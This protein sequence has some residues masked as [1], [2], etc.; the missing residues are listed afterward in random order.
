MPDLS[1]EIGLYS[2]SRGTESGGQVKVAEQLLAIDALKE[3]SRG[4]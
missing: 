4:K 1:L 2:P 3:F